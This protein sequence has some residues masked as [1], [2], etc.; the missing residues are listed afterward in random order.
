MSALKF[1]N[2]LE[3]CESAILRCAGFYV[4]YCFLEV[5]WETEVLKV[6]SKCRLR[7]VE[8]NISVKAI[9]SWMWEIEIHTAGPGGPAA[10]VS[11]SLPGRP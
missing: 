7:I 6:A 9:W 4:K 2:K 1:Q 5:V 10:P 8:D 11:P 3:V